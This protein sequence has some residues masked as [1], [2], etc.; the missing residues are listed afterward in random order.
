MILTDWGI[1]SVPT[2]LGGTRPRP[3]TILSPEIWSPP[4]PGSFKLNFDGAA[5]GN[6]G[7][8]GYGGLVRDTDGSVLG[9]FWGDLGEC[10]NNLAEL[11]GLIHGLRWASSQPWSPL[12][13]E[14]DS[15]LII[16]LVTRLQAGSNISKISNNWRWESRLMELQGILQTG[17]AI[18]FQHIKRKGNKVADALANKG[19]GSGTSFHEVLANQEAGN[20]IIKHYQSLAATDLHPIGVTPEMHTTVPP[21]SAVNRHQEER[22]ASAASAVPGI[23]MEGPPS[24]VAGAEDMSSLRRDQD[25]A[26][27]HE[28]WDTSPR[29]GLMASG[30][31]HD[32]QHV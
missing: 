7:P 27:M 19:V 4:G 21:T 32:N 6:P 25:V 30:P 9:V 26:A 24:N 11:E 1:T 16:S 28:G 29:S 18:T 31:I 22:G 17:Q 10:S 2:F 20:D 12:L 14:G 15:R 3:V 5:K 8:A 23:R 13:V